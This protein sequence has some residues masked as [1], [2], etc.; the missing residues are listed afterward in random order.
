MSIKIT[1]ERR[2][3]IA[4]I[5]AVNEQ[6]LYQCLTGRRDMSPAEAMRL[7]V[8]TGKELTRQ[9]LCQKTYAGIWPELA[10]IEPA[11][12]KEVQGLI[13]EATA[14]LTTN[15]ELAL[16]FVKAVDEGLVKIATPK[17]TATPRPPPGQ[18]DG[19]TFTRS[20]DAPGHGRRASD[21]PAAYQER[22][23]TKPQN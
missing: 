6:Y 12:E 2:K 21:K 3:Q 14:P 15:P 19:K 1:P 23:K 7:E 17:P 10:A 5:H 18:W 13:Q 8:E 4:S 11:E 9:M 22:R 16:E 20:T